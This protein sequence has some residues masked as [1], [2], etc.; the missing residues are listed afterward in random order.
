MGV[1]GESP[2][3]YQFFFQQNEYMQAKLT[4][5]SFWEQPTPVLWQDLHRCI[6]FIFEIYLLCSHDT[7]VLP[8][9]LYFLKGSTAT[10][11]LAQKMKPA[12][13]FLS[14]AITQSIL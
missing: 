13:F 2:R 3:S 8:K 4:N 14:L 11:T 9:A 6:S 1:Q 7:H 12:S 10:I 5:Q